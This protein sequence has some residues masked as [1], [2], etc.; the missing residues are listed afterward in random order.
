MAGKFLNIV[1]MNTASP[2]GTHPRRICGTGKTSLPPVI[3]EG[4]CG[5]ITPQ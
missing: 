3:R 2:D 1:M 5:G 4:P